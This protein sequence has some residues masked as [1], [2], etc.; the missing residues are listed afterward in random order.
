EVARS[1]AA[2]SGTLRFGTGA[3]RPFVR[4]SAFCTRPSGALV[5]VPAAIKSTK[6]SAA[7]VP[8]GE[9]RTKA[10]EVSVPKRSVPKRSVPKGE[11]RTTDKPMPTITP[12]R[13]TPENF[14]PY[15]TVVQ[16]PAG[17]PLAEG[18]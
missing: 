16:A 7:S 15:G 8:K 10:N 1:P 13:I 6:A 14:A 2:R 11:A 18:P 5:G 3:A 17:A 4:P 9:A 12:V